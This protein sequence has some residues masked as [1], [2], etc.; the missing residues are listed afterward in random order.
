MHEQTKRDLLESGTGAVASL[1]KEMMVHRNQIEV[2]EKQKEKEMELAKARAEAREAN[3][4]GN[5]SD[6]SLPDAATASNAG[7]SQD[8]QVSATPGE[9]EAAL[10]ELID[11]E[12]CSVCR[13]LLVEL[14]E[15]P[16]REQVRGIMEYGTF[17][18]NLDDGAGV[19]ELKET[20]KQTDVLHSV[21]QEKY[22]GTGADA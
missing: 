9:I 14:K 8:S 1:L 19:E 6:T 5:G 10:D 18:S 21:F 16:P 22:T 15:R 7:A 17:K 2:L 20:I 12:M 3:D 13:D 4:G 11:E